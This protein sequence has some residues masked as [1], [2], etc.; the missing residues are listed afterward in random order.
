MVYWVWVLML[1]GMTLW[2]LSLCRSLLASVQLFTD[3]QAV[4]DAGPDLDGGGTFRKRLT[5]DE[6]NKRSYLWLLALCAGTTRVYTLV[7]LMPEKN[8]RQ[9][10]VAVAIKLGKQTVGYLSRDSARQ[11]C[12]ALQTKGWPVRGITCPAAITRRQTT[13]YGLWLDL[14]ALS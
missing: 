7:T 5:A 8:T 4:L 13:G 6:V 11:F 12:L 9:R 3:R 14:P 1:A 10:S 2:C